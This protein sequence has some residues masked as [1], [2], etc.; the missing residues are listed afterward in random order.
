MRPGTL[1]RDAQVGPE[2]HCQQMPTCSLLHYLIFSNSLNLII[3]MLLET[4]SAVIGEPS[5]CFLC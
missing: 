3:V 1:L 4:W 5:A 2:T